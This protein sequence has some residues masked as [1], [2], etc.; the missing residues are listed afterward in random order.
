M[1]RMIEHSE[2]TLRKRLLFSRLWGAIVILWSVI[3]T[4]II[5]AAL[6]GYGFNPWI[7]L[8]IDL[9]CSA[10]DAFTT[11]RMVLRFVDDRYASAIKWGVVSLIAYVIPDIYIFA[12]TRTLPK[13]VIVVLCLVIVAM[14]SLAVVTIVRKVRKGR[15][16]RHDLEAAGSMQGHA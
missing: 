3:R 16:L 8:S 6:G 5:W 11:P 10:F 1:S 7:Y 14:S 12:G 9:V 15:E 13:K 4:V 2:D